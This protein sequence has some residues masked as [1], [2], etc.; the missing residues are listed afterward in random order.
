[1]NNV[2]CIA[3]LNMLFLLKD[4]NL[5]TYILGCPVLN[6]EA[7]RESSVKVTFLVDSTAKI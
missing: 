4:Y 2:Q 3:G 6:E 5:D 1:M 7:K